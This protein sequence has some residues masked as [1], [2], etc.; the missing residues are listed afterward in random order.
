MIFQCFPCPEPMEP[1]P[2]YLTF[3]RNHSNLYFSISLLPTTP[4][5]LWP[6]VS[7]PLSVLKTAISEKNAGPAAHTITT[8]PR[9]FRRVLGSN[10]SCLHSGH[11][12][13]SVSFFSRNSRKTLS[14]NCA[15]RIQVCPKKG[16]GPRSIP[17]LCGWDWNQKNPIRSGG[18][19]ILG[20]GLVCF[21]TDST[22]IIDPVPQGYSN[23]GMK[24]AKMS[25]KLNSI[26]T[27]K[28]AMSLCLK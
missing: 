26:S 6:L 23:Q 13:A 27:S 5:T 1:Q 20:D 21:Q 7:S 25:H 11:R 4:E 2:P 12:F 8:P 3:A 9:F 22:Y 17:I 10:T 24:Q 18:V 15:L 28:S 16:M 19:W 14:S